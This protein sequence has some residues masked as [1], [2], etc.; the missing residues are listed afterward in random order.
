L[1]CQVGRVRPRFECATKTDNVGRFVT[2]EDCASTPS[3]GP[4]L[5][6]I[7][8]LKPVNGQEEWILN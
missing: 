3:N 7:N 4:C 6:G 8:H 5:N 1:L 2:I